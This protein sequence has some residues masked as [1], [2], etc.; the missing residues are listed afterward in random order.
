LI[1]FS[2]LTLRYFRAI[3]S[4]STLLA[5]QTAAI[6]RAILSVCLSVRHIKVFC[7]E[8]WRYDRADSWSLSEYSQGITPSE[9]V[10]VKHPPI[11]SENLT[12]NRP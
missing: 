1:I 12:N 7:P 2:D 6:A 8:E 11:A 4:A 5:M 3:Y 10:K 9:G